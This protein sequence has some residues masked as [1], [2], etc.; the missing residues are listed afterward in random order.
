MWRRQR[1][2]LASPTR[3]TTNPRS[4]LDEGQRARIGAQIADAYR[5]QPQTA[6]ELA[7]LERATRALVD[8]QPW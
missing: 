2:G 5:H 7:G 1:N 3:L 8:D 4:P 6:E